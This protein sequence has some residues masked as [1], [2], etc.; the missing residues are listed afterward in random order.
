MKT[1]SDY[2][3]LIEEAI[4]ALPLSSEKPYSLFAPIVYGLQTGG[5][6]LRP[7][8]TLL[9]YSLKKSD[10]QEAM[11]IALAHEVFHNFTLLHD[12][13]MDNS[14]VR[15]G[16]PSV[17]SQFGTNSAILSGDAMLLYAVRLLLQNGET[18]RDARIYPL[19]VEMALDVMRGQEMDMT[20]EQKDEVT[21][22]EYLQMIHLKT[23]VLIA[24]AARLGAIASGATSEEEEWIYK[25]ALNLGIAFQLQDDL[26]D[27]YGDPK[28]F[29]KP[30]GGDI[31]EGKKTILYLSALGNSRSEE[32]KKA[33]ISAYKMP[34]TF[35]QEKIIA[36]TELFNS[37][38]A[39]DR[40]QSMITRYMDLSDDALHSLHS[41][42]YDISLL[43]QLGEKM[44]HRSH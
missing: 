39:K 30:I 35:A 26:L 18:P 7:L 10:P 14:L 28:T 12:D 24:S 33:L 31:I 15:R 27:V 1:L 38:G 8:I 44:R 16:K 20:F 23:A 3:Q 4:E 6:R 5:K 37:L 22:E 13:V 42:G 21:I 36:I 11:P 32:E 25:F 29:G 9:T 17:M 41:R 19:F 43:A 34:A 2:S 40:V